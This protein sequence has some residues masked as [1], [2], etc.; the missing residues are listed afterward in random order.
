MRGKLQATPDVTI[1]KRIIPAHAGQTFRVVRLGLGTADHPRACGA[2]IG[3]RFSMRPACGS[4]PRMRGKLARY[5]YYR[6]YPRIIPA[7]AGQ[8]H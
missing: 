7:H 6:P 5:G 4:S 3:S 1:T 2:N 8:T